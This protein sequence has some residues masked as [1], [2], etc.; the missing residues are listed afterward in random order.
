MTT[1]LHSS[2]FYWS[3]PPLCCV[4]RLWCSA[5]ALKLAVPAVLSDDLASL[6]ILC[7]V[8]IPMWPPDAADFWHLAGLL[9]VLCI[10]S[11][12]CWNLGLK[13][14]YTLCRIPLSCLCK[15]LHLFQSPSI[16]ES[17]ALYTYIHA[18]E[19]ANNIYS[20]W[21]LRTNSTSSWMMKVLTSFE[22]ITWEV[23]E[24]NSMKNVY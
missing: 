6:A 8:R 11:S 14:W 15:T 5:H 3:G 2:M 4:M 22:Y 20:T 1:V 19:L 12:A 23:E 7:T 16:F 24:G 10:V 9:P 21:S 17:S 18:T 13:Y